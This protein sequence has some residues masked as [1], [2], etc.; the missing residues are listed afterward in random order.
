T[1]PPEIPAEKQAILNAL[2]HPKLT[3]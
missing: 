3:H 1:F 2:Q